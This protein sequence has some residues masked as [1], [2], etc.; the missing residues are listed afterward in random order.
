MLPDVLSSAWQFMD[1]E[2]RI[3][4]VSSC[5]DHIDQW[6]SHITWNPALITH[7]APF[8]TYSQT[9]NVRCTKSQN[10]NVFLSRLAVVFA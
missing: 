4:P 1:F 5:M 7:R 3:F 9:F 10:S 2:M 8:W 6:A